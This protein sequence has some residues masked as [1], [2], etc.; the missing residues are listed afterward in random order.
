MAPSRKS[1]P[2]RNPEAK[3]DNQSLKGRVALVAG[4]TRGVG[5]GI[6]LALGE[7]GATVY[8]T[9]R[10]SRA[11]ESA[12]AARRRRRGECLA[13]GDYPTNTRLPTRTGAGLVGAG[14]SKGSTGRH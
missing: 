4:A 11:A 3:S 7:A 9:G 1:P 12:N 13:H 8:C 2:K 14:I 5:R 6:A 10:S